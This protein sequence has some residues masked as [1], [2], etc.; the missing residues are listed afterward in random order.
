MASKGIRPM[1]KLE[2]LEERRRRA[3][4]LCTRSNSPFVG[5]AREEVNVLSLEILEEKIDTL[6]ER[7]NDIRS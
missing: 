7:L 2:Q 6:L 1:T 3:Q 4:V 5:R